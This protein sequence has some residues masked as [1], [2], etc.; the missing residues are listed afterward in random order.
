MKKY[1]GLSLETPATIAT[2]GP[3]IERKCPV[4]GQMLIEFF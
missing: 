4:G 2:K 1:T 3:G